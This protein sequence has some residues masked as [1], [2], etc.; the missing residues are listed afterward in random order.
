MKT[1]TWLV[2]LAA[3]ALIALVAVAVGCGGNDNSGTT[4]SS[5]GNATDAAFITDMTA[6]HQGAIEMAE[7]AQRQAD[8]AEIRTLAEDIISA[9]KGEMSVMDAIGRDMRAMGMHEGGHMGMSQS[10]MG[11]EMDMPML[12]RAKPFDRAFI[13]MMVPHHQGAI[14]MAKQ[15][16]NKGEQPALRRMANDIVSAQTDEIAQMRKWRKAWYGST[17]SS[18]D[19][20]HGSD[21]SMHGDN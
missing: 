4:S 5:S 15:L 17:G 7:V 14:A 20:M 8:H 12:R 11:M 1:K 19:S 16:L 9:Q 6:H 21:E 10:Q 18:G 2:L 13:D 3:L